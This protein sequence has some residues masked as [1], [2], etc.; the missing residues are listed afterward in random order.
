MSVDCTLLF[1]QAEIAPKMQEMKELEAR[2]AKAKTALEQ[3]A[4]CDPDRV[5][6]LGIWRPTPSPLLFWGP[7]MPSMFL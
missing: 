1:T 3:Y 7:H 6:A 5:R 4:E 2:K